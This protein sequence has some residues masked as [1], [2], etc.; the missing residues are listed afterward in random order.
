VGS[1]LEPVV[2]ATIE[3]EVEDEIREAFEFAE[4]S[5]FPPDEELYTDMCEA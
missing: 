4:A 2:R 5:P 3:A 1:L